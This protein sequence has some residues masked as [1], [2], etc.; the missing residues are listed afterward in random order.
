MSAGIVLTD[1]EKAAW[2]QIDNAER[3]VITSHVHPDG[4]AVG[5]ALALMYYCKAKGKKVHIVID[6]HIPVIYRFLEG[7]EIIREQESGFN[8]ELLIIVDTNPKRIG[9]CSKFETAVT[10]NI[11]HHDT[12]PK[13]CD[14]HIIRE[15]SSSTAELLYCIF[16]NE[17]FEIT[18]S[19]ADCLY[20][21]VI[22]DTVFF[23]AP[24]VT[25]NTFEVAANLV[26]HGARNV[27]IAEIV[28]EQ[29]YEET[30]L[31]ARAIS[32]VKSYR[33]GTIVGAVLDESF[34]TLELTD[35]V[36]DSIRYIRGV[37]IA[38]LLKHE[39]DGTYRVRMRSHKYNLTS[40]AKWFGG[41]G[42]PDAAGFSIWKSDA[43]EA[44]QFFRGELERW[45]EQ[46]SG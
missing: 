41:G 29:T 34:D 35:L 32:L 23:K 20:T 39:E 3:I 44:E 14:Y 19:I 9:C 18:S 42:H 12:N 4:D 7:V 33:Q 28:S 5:S 13:L 43:G 6:D 24:S 8:A 38:Y 26:K 15:E 37:E 22:T 30:Q 2:R 10:L 27:M 25:A 36:I 17:N 21:G 1:E 11:D 40:F 46:Y 16:E 45:L 31:I